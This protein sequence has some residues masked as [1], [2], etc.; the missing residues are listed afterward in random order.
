M[1]EKKSFRAV[2]QQKRCLR[3]RALGR[4]TVADKQYGYVI[5]LVRATGKALY[6]FQNF[7]LELL[8]R[9]IVLAGK[10]FSEASYYEKLVVRFHRFRDAIAEKNQRI[11]RA[12]MFGL[13]RVICFGN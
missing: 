3:S 13:G 8:Q 2:A 11:S 5:V 12:K 4:S 10:H 1:E 7:S 6:R 9:N